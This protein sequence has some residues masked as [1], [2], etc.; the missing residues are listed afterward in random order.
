MTGRI[1][2]FENPNFVGPAYCFR[3]KLN[4]LADVSWSDRAQS[5]TVQGKHWVAYTD[6]EQEG[7][8]LRGKGEFV[9]YGEG[10]H[11]LSDK[12]K[13]RIKFLRLVTEAL[14]VRKIELYQHTDYKGRKH[15]AQNDETDLKNSK[16]DNMASSHKVTGGVWILYDGPHFTGDCFIAFK[17]DDIQDYG[18]YKYNDKVS[19]LQPLNSDDFILPK[20][21][22]EN[23]ADPA[24]EELS[25]P[26]AGP[27]APNSAL[28]STD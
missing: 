6:M 12:M 5:L 17:G 24:T 8:G 26:N 19:S 3:D 21:A 7:E 9:V 4:N 10:D 14:D 2:L 27:S 18:K 16:F 28:P 25:R 22:A 15:I 23:C 13:E 20:S 11:V 1:I